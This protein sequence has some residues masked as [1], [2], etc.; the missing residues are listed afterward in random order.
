MKRDVG[1][2]VLMTTL[3][4]G[5]SQ[6]APWVKPYQQSQVRHPVMAVSVDPPLDRERQRTFGQIEGARG[7]SQ[8]GGVCGC[9]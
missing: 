9:N 3:L 1:L 2:A 6:S 5:C 8:H 7:A 4:C